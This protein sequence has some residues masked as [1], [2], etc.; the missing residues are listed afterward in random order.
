MKAAAP[1]CSG[2]CEGTR[3]SPSSVVFV[4]L[5][6]AFRR[7]VAEGTLNVDAVPGI[8]KRVA[9]DREL[10]GLIDVSGSILTAAETLVTAQP[11]P[12][13]DATRSRRGSYS[14]PG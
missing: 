11:L 7:R 14:P 2:C 6:S 4:E 5:R 13:L 1:R 8:L 12:T 3:S 9:A 10:W